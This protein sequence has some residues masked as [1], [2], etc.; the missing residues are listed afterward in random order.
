[1]LDAQPCPVAHNCTDDAGEWFFADRRY[2]SG[3]LSFAG[4][5]VDVRFE[6]A[7]QRQQGGGVRDIIS[8]WSAA[9]RRRF[10]YRLGSIDLG[11][12]TESWGGR[13]VFVT[14]TWREDPGPAVVGRQ[15]RA[16]KERWRR[17]FGEVRW[18]WKLEFQMR[19]V[20]HFH[21]LAWVPFDDDRSLATLRRWVWSAWEGVS[22][23]R[24]RVDVGWCQAK[25]VARYIAF[26][27]TKSTKAYQ[28]R[29]PATWRSTGRWWGVDGLP[30]YWS[31]IPVSVPELVV[32]RRMLRRYRRANS[33][34][35][36]R[37]G[38]CDGLSRVWVLGQETGS[39]IGAVDRLL[40]T[41]ARG[42]PSA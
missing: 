6:A 35:R 1:M 34:R 32:V 3:T 38:R 8:C 23:D 10:L 7:D 13:F 24:H 9:S 12:L 41:L 39:L 40:A 4:R 33:R 31:S 28:F 30:V 37:F 14:L 18:T 21:V 11:G 19:G 42:D 22:G 2:R 27:L 36:P 15:R 16:L 25:D 26:D 20:P 5:V 29:V 17:R